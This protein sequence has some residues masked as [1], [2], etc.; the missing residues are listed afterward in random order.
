MVRHSHV[1]LH[2][3]GGHEL[4]RAFRAL[5]PQTATMGET[6]AVDHLA[7]AL[8]LRLE[9]GAQQNDEPLRSL[10]DLEYRFRGVLTNEEPRFIQQVTGVHSMLRYFHPTQLRAR[11][12]ALAEVI[13]TQASRDKLVHDHVEEP[14]S[15]RA[16]GGRGMAFPAPQRRDQ[17]WDPI[18]STTTEAKHDLENIEHHFSRDQTFTSGSV[19]TIHMD[20]SRSNVKQTMARELDV[21][22]ARPGSARSARD[23]RVGPSLSK[24]TSPKSELRA[25]IYALIVLTL[26]S[27]F[28]S[29]SSFAWWLSRPLLLLPLHLGRS[30]RGIRE[31][32]WRCRA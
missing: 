6:V 30:L 17:Q 29:L 11:A 27:R 20:K 16:L 31:T 32:P 12:Q 7:A 8:A 23:P 28:V 19:I 10:R 4:E 3:T 2:V 25:P 14:P 5:Q 22:V 9:V 26:L 21:E 18:D 1:V 13:A 15:L 24:T